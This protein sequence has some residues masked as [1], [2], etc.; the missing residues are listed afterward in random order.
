[1]KELEAAVYDGR[2]HHDGHPVLKWCISNLLTRE[3]GL[4]SY[5]MPMKSRPEAKIDCAVALLIAM[6]Q[7]RLL[8]VQTTTTW[9]FE[10]FVA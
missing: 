4:G 10:P 1:M 2:F 5:T 3:S 6:T 9:A 7:A 8:P